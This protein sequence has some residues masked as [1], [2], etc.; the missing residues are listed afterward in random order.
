M[1]AFLAPDAIPEE[2]LR[3]G[4]AH[5]GPVLAPLAADAFTIT[6]VMGVLLRYS[7]IKRS[8]ESRTLSIHHLVQVVL[9]DAMSQETARDW[10]ER[11]VQAVNV[12]FPDVKYGNWPQYERLLP[13]ALA[14][15]ELIEQYALTFS[16]AARLLDQTTFYLQE[17]A[18]YQE[19]EP[20]YQRAQRSGNS[21]WGRSTPTRP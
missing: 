12:A 3:E 16:E 9:K 1:C 8:R 21:S 19:A 18:R 5:L 13:H 20:L 7:L 14:S 6:E 17:R 10:A 2:L 15:A 4:A 11:T